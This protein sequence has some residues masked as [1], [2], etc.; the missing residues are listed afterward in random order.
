MNLAPVSTATL[1]QMPPSQS[2]QIEN[3]NCQESQQTKECKSIP[4][5]NM[6]NMIGKFAPSLILT[7]ISGN[8]IHVVC[9]PGQQNK[10]AQG[11]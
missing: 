4:L 1:T 8:K 11:S 10:I 6:Q 9:Q 2:S 7:Q 5:N 3:K